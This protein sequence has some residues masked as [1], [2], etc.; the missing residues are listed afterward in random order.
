M[1]SFR[2]SPRWVSVVRIRLI[3]GY[4]CLSNHLYRVGVKASPLCTLCNENEVTAKY[5][6]MLCPL[7]TKTTFIYRYLEATSRVGEWQIVNFLPFE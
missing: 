2:D 1:K 6:L 3:N 7:L 4:K 5:H